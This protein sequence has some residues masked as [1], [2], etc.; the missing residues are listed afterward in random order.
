MGRIS[1]ADADHYGNQK[2]GSWFSLKDDHDTARVRFMYESIDDVQMDVVHEVEVDGKKRYVNCIR[3]YNEPAD[4]C[5]LC[6]AGYKQNVKIFVPVYNE[7]AGEVQIWQR[8]KTFASQLSALINRYNPLCGT[9]IEIE[10]LGKKGDQGTTY[11]TY[12]LQSDGKTLKDLPE[13]PTLLG[14]IIMD[15]TFDELDYFVGHG[16]F[17]KIEERSDEP[18]VARRGSRPF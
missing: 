10:R 3:S 16:S 9:P 12:P 2:G 14:G 17:E 7:S 1:I 5:P 15:K 6:R 18:V 13:V 4:N 8:G 11:Q